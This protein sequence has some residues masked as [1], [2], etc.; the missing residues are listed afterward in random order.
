MNNMKKQISFIFMALGVVIMTASSCKEKE[1]APL[2]NEDQ[3]TQPLNPTEI[4]IHYQVVDENQVSITFVTIDMDS[5]QLH[6]GFGYETP[7]TKISYS[8][9]RDTM[10]TVVTLDRTRAHA[11]ADTDLLNARI[12]NI[13]DGESV[14]YRNY[15][16][17]MAEIDW[18][19]IA[20]VS[21]HL[22]VPH[23]TT[24]GARIYFDASNPTADDIILRF[25]ADFAGETEIQTYE[26]H[27]GDNL[28]NEFIEFV[29][30]QPENQASYVVYNHAT[31]EELGSGSFTTTRIHFYQHT[32][33]GPGTIL[34]NKNQESLGSVLFD[35]DGN[36]LCDK[37]VITFVDSVAGGKM[38][39]APW[40]YFFSLEIAEMLE[41][42][43][44]ES[45]WSKNGDEYSVE[46]ALSDVS[47]GKDFRTLDIS[48]TTMEKFP[49]SEK[50]S[51]YVTLYYQGSKTLKTNQVLLSL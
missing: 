16:L 44:H 9:S 46:I 37:A 20:E 25:E 40:E 17:D 48:S 23:P 14:E 32:L 10:V 8:N 13:Q 18:N 3:Q 28:T 41:F 12:T 30:S 45:D 1:E 47:I 50:I 26:L 51:M 11:Q 38:A 4:G 34:E 6:Y 33:S 49:H 2:P 42:T 39:F 31:N 36:V 22:D 7:K 19:A 35:A 27:S 5:L 15:A 29:G 21:F 24:N 43:R